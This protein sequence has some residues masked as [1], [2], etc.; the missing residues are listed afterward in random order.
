MEFLEAQAWLLRVGVG[1][2]PRVGPWR[3]IS[4]VN[5]TSG[6]VPSSPHFTTTKSYTIWTHPIGQNYRRACADLIPDLRLNSPLL[7]RHRSSCRLSSQHVHHFHKQED[8]ADELEYVQGHFQQHQNP[9]VLLVT[10][11]GLYVPDCSTFAHAFQ[12]LVYTR[13]CSSGIEQFYITTVRVLSKRASSSYQY[14]WYLA[15]T[16]HLHSPHIDRD[17]N[18]R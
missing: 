13:I 3:V 16:T 7:F 6:S 12:S 1:T 15:S 17:R 10:Y 2:L 11:S 8:R 4:R 18:P 14:R 5:Q 9:L